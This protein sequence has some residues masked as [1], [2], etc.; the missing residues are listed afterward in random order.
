MAKITYS[1]VDRT[2][3]EKTLLEKK[4]DKYAVIYPTYASVAPN[5]MVDE[6][7]DEQRQYNA[8]DTF[9]VPVPGNDSGICT[10]IF[11]V[12]ADTPCL[13]R[14]FALRAILASAGAYC[15]AKKIPIIIIPAAMLN[16][17]IDN[18]IDRDMLNSAITEILS[19]INIDVVVTPNVTEDDY[20]ALKDL[21]PAKDAFREREKALDE[22]DRHVDRVLSG[23]KSKKGK[24][25]D[26]KSKKG[27]KKNKK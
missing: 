19:G 25:K 24:K 2:E 26:K 8:G 7:S 4:E 16:E 21:Q 27:K 10:N 22:I 18:N 1:A 9:V 23:K 12:L 20:K 6:Q 15:R 11:G 17:V 5:T 14:Y 3:F 13:P